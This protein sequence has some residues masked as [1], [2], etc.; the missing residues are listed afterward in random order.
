M[1]ILPKAQEGFESGSYF[2]ASTGLCFIRFMNTVSD[3]LIKHSSRANQN[4]PKLKDNENSANKKK[5][6]VTVCH[7]AREITTTGPISGSIPIPR[8]GTALTPWLLPAGWLVAGRTLPW[9][10]CQPQHNTH[11]KGC[12][13]PHWQLHLQSHDLEHKGLVSGLPLAVQME[14]LR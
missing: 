6:F 10:T 8:R 11:P 12:T 5:L 2:T 9:G 1:E 14:P 7:L 4:S 3:W 13:L